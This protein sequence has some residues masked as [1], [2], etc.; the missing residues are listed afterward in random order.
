MQ[1]SRTSNPFRLLERYRGVLLRTTMVEVRTQYAGS[2]LGLLWVLLGPLLLLVLY[3]VV[4][5]M[6]F[7]IRPPTLST[8]EY[9]LYVFAGLIPTIAFSAALNFGA[10]SLVQNRQILLNT[11]FPAELLP[12]RS[13]LVQSLALP[14]GLAFVA[15]GVAAVKGSLPIQAIIVPLLIVLQ[16]M[17]VTGLA[18]VLSLVTLAARDVQQ[19]LQYVSITLLIIT[20]IAYTPDMIPAPLRVLTYGNP[21]YYFTAAYQSVLVFGSWPSTLEFGVCVALALVSFTGGFWLF[22]RV[23]MTFYDYA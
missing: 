2:A 10:G 9:V 17:F 6:I 16:I 12:V 1:K 3:S 19:L 11:V 4:Y 8:A 13:V 15:A 23:K 5:V 18:W 20:P 21:L 7:R 22:Q 14:V